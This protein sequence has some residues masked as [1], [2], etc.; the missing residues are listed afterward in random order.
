MLAMDPRVR[1]IVVAGALSFLLSLPARAVSGRVQDEHGNPIV[2][3]QACL[4]LSK[5]PTL[6]V[7]TDTT[8]SFRLADTRMLTVRITADGYMPAMVAAVDQEAPVVLQ[9]AASLFV[10][11]VDGA[12]GEALGGGEIVVTDSSG[13]KRG[14]FPFSKAGV[15][16]R[17]IAPGEVS[18][19]C[20]LAGYSAEASW[21]AS[22]VAGSESAVT[23]R[24]VQSKN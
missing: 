12:S 11:V 24:P 6:C 14:T 10:R 5:S 18:I 7:V 16:V 15:R 8:G 17:E 4:M 1:I 20:V 21:P 22:L 23:L 19:R 3:A 9:R 2:G 13:R